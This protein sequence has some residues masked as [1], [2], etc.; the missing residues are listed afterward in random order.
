[1][2]HRSK[3][4]IL[5][6]KS[7]PLRALLRGLAESIIL[8][9]KVKTTEAK[10]KTVRPFV[11]RVITAGKTPSLV[12]RRKLMTI[13]H[14]ELPVKKILEE[15]GPRYKNRAGGYTR[16]IKLGTRLNDAAEMVQIELV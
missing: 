6:R 3:K 12:A 4:K 7:E 13:F 11:E 14:T 8:F 1:M 10:A 2:R 9:E 5:G 16:I 15:L